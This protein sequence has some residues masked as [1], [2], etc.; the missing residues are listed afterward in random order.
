M[1]V[2]LGIKVLFIQ[3]YI[4]KFKDYKYIVSK[5]DVCSL[6]EE[7][8][9]FIDLIM[10]YLGCY[11]GKALERMTHCEKPSRDKKRLIP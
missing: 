6:D 3:R 9:F 4:V 5:N 2:R 10:R 11:S 7:E 8:Q 1:I